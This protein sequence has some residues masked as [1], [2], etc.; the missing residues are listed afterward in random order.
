MNSAGARRCDTNAE[1]AGVFGVAGGHERCCFF[2]ADLNEAYFVGA[3]AQRL[4]DA[5]DAVTGHSEHHINAPVMDR[6]DQN[7]GRSSFHPKI[8]FKFGTCMYNSVMKLGLD[9]KVVLIT[10]GSKG[11]GL[12]CARVFAQEGS[13]VA[14]ASRSEDNLQSARQELSK[15]GLNVF[16]VRA[17]FRE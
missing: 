15:D 9:G 6:I 2:M 12:A 4:Y 13:H 10:G 3:L 14:I 17:D 1:L 11:I 7:I 5:V 8:P 16:T